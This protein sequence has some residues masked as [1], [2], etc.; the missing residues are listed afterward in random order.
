[1]ILIFIGVFLLIVGINMKNAKNVWDEPTKV[2]G[3]KGRNAAIGAVIGAVGGGALAAVI[4]G[5]GVVV[6]GT[7]F[8]LPAGAALI[9]TAASVGAGAGAIGGAA[10]GKSTATTTITHVVP[11]Y[12]IWQWGSVIAV[13]VILLIF[14]ILEIKKIQQPARAI[15]N[16]GNEK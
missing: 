15:E 8:G 7:G 16:A 3:T 6:A 1:M 11:A 10:I 12:E 9:A 5:F 14:A 4:G 2:P 13:G